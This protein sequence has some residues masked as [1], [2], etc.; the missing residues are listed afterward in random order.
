[1]AIATA[2]TG[3]PSLT[4][5][6]TFSAS[7]EKIFQ[8]WTDCAQLTR[9]FGPGRVEAIQ[10]SVDLKVGGRYHIRMRSA[11]GE[12]HNVG[13]VYREIIPNRKLVFTWAWVSTPERE[14]LVTVHIE[15][16]GKKCRLTLVH[17]KFFDD[18]VRDRHA[19]GWTGSLDK[20]SDLL[21]AEGE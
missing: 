3:K 16:D 10:A 8:A 12:D 1:M 2:E 18:S 11:D 15:P 14:S 4:L 9:W 19:G 6:R 20:L 13:G 21:A 7:P 17:E 5:V